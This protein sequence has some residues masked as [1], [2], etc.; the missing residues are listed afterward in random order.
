[1]YS[2]VPNPKEVGNEEHTV[3]IARSELI[4]SDNSALPYCCSIRAGPQGLIPVTIVLMLTGT[5][6]IQSH[7]L[8]YALNFA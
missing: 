1:M 6:T 5:C 2:C 7:T 4:S 3:V 8:N